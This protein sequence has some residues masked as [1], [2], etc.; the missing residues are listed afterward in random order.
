MEND[1]ILKVVKNISENHHKIIDDW[2]KAYMAQIY[3]EKGSIKPG[4][5]ILNQQAVNEEGKFGFK[6]WFTLK[7]E[8]KIDLSN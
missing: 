4:D 5:F 8:I 3:Q 6:Y 7:E 1:T 2:C